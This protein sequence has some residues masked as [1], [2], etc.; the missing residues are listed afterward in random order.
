MQVDYGEWRPRRRTSTSPFLP[1]S[2]AVGLASGITVLADRA[3]FDP[4]SHLPPP[5]PLSASSDRPDPSDI[6][7]LEC[8][9]DRKPDH[10]YS[11]HNVVRRPMN[12]QHNR[13]TYR[14]DASGTARRKHEEK[15]VREGGR[16]KEEAVE[17]ATSHVKGLRI[18][19]VAG[20]S[21]G[22]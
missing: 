13:G 4:F 16:R 14:D 18:I 5:P 11:A 2:T 7:V 22:R 20:V 1:A 21:A 9:Q 10:R 3:L 12:P 19:R 6:C 15:D 8:S 17:R